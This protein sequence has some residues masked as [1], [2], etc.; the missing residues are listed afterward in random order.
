MGGANTLPAQNLHWGG[1]VYTPGY[2]L[3]WVTHYGPNGPRI[4][5]KM[6]MAETVTIVIIMS[7]STGFNFMPGSL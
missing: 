7:I 2:L 5:F 6:I 1:G 4:A 3:R